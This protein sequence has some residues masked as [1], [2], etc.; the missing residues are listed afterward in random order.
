MIA[1]SIRNLKRLSPR[2][3]RS[4][5]PMGLILLYHRVTDY[6]VDPWRLCVSPRNF[7]DQ[8][9]ELNRRFQP[10]PLDEF[11]R[12]NEAG[13]LPEG[14]VALTFDDGY[15]DNFRHAFPILEATGAPATIFVATGS[16]GSPHEFWWDELERLLFEPEFLPSALTLDLLGGRRSWDL[17][18]A[19]RWRVADSVRHRSWRPWDDRQPTMRHRMYWELWQ[20]L[21]RTPPDE[22]AS[23]LDEIRSWSGMG[24]VGRSSNLAMTPAELQTLAQSRFI[25]LGAHTRSHVA[26]SALSSDAQRVEIQGSRDDLAQIIGATQM[27]F[28]YPFGR[29]ADFNDD[30]L[31]LVKGAGFAGACVNFQAAV[32]ASTDRFQLPRI[33]VQDWSGRNLIDR[34]HKWQ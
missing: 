16:T 3:G 24:V 7:R 23:V 31:A 13:E 30:T 11:I 17:G 8:V 10:L 9:S 33:Q 6:S 18:D 26:L 27:C 32:N 34:L 5:K 12:L 4:R 22:R 29:R 1:K 20:S 28:S 15:S 19:A 21:H 2:G 25:A 14:A